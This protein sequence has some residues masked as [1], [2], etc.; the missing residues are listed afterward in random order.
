MLIEVLRPTAVA[1]SVSDP[2]GTPPPQGSPC[3]ITH[4][5]GSYKSWSNTPQSGPSRKGYPSFGVPIGIHLGLLSQPAFSL[6]Q[7]LSSLPFHWH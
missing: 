4:H 2:N 1:A 3:L 7:I 5:H 6:C